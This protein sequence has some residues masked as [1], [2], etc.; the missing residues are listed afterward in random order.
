VSLYGIWPY[1][2]GKSLVCR[3]DG[4][5]TDPYQLSQATARMIGEGLFMREVKGGCA[6]ILNKIKGPEAG[7][8]IGL[9]LEVK[10]LIKGSC[11][12]GLFFIKY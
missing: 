5:E 1:G 11:L 8:Q 12:C 6:T 10:S 3:I 7:F 2:D 4:V 9:E